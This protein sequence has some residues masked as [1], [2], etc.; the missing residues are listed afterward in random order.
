M[1]KFK[2]YVVTHKKFNYKLLDSYEPIQVGKCNTH[3]ELP[4]ITDDSGDNISNKNSNYCELTA[5]YW[6][7]KNI[8][9]D[10]YVGIC[11]YRRYFVYG[12]NSKLVD[13]KYISKYLDS[14]KYDIILPYE[15]KTESNVY[16]HF[17][18][19]T[20]GRKKDLENLRIVIKK[21]SP[22]YLSSYDYIMESR[23]ASY[24]N[25]MISSKN[26]FD[27]YCKWLFD[28]LFE[29]E[30]IT[31]LTGYSKQEQRIYGFLSEFLLNVWVKH[32]NLKIKHC[33]MYY[34]EDNKI[35]N[36]LKKVKL[37]VRSVIK[38]EL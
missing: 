4:Y 31:D 29:L 6:I 35:K 27:N 33:S 18:N 10:G 12:V 16:E 30:K 20:S 8:H 36:K 11:H 2:M 26:I 25:M 37:G 19:S 9:E 32:N 7:W 34:I 5:I 28:I 38:N 21:I 1:K 17:I 23:K 24:C 13:D 14:K 3:N 22:E 15:Y